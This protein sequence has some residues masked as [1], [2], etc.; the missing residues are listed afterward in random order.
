MHGN[1]LDQRYWWFSFS[2]LGETIISNRDPATLR[3]CDPA[4]L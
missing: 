1:L 4:T 3:S 2:E